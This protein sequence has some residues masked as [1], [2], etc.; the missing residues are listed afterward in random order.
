MRVCTECD[1]FVFAL[2]TWDVWPN[3]ESHIPV[4]QTFN[5]NNDTKLIWN[6]RQNILIYKALC[7]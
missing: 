4:T 7:T 6:T 3:A 2:G 5:C 1:H